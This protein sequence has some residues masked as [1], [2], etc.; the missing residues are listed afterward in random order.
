MANAQIDW[1]KKNVYVAV[2]IIVAIVGVA[3]LL[4]GKHKNDQKFVWAGGAV[5]AGAAVVGIGGYFLTK[6]DTGTPPPP[7]GGTSYG[8]SS[9]MMGG[10]GGGGSTLSERLT[11]STADGIHTAKDSLAAVWDWVWKYKV[12]EGNAIDLY[13]L[14]EHRFATTWSLVKVGGGALADAAQIRLVVYKPDDTTMHKILLSSTYGTLKNASA[15]DREQMI[16]V[17]DSFSVPPS[18]IL[19]LEAYHATEQVDVS[20][21][22]VTIGAIRRS[23]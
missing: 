7:A 11:L 21:S 4:W 8:G 22:A 9:L 18:W 19:A 3:L 23:W 10:G 13:R 16:T 2:A 20:A 12:P 15:Y 6:K 14:F 17:D 5:I 1:L